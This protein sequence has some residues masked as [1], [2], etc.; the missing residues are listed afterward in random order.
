[1]RAALLGL[2]AL[3]LA[4]PASASPTPPAD[5]ASY[6][7]AAAS[8]THAGC[9]TLGGSPALSGGTPTR[10]LRLVVVTGAATA[11]LSCSGETLKSVTVTLDGPGTAG[12][13]V[14]GDGNCWVTATAT[15]TRIPTTAVVS[16][17]S[18]YVFK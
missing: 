9:A 2:C 11:T 14:E 10:D 17:T 6:L 16:N 4:V 15:S 3:G 7:L 18:G 8:G 1:M 5:C 13:Y 12:G